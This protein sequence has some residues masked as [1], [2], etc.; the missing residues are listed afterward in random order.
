MKLT[1]WGFWKKGKLTL[2]S[3]RCDYCGLCAIRCPHKA[4]KVDSKNNEWKISGICMR[5]GRCVRECPNA[6]LTIKADK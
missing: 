2:D 4:L 6:A 3:N 1:H 5:C